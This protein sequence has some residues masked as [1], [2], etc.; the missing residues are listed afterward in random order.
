MKATK[1]NVKSRQ[2]TLGPPVGIGLDV[3][4][5]AFDRQ[6]VQ[7]MRRYAGQYVALSGGSVVDHDPDDEALA[8]RMFKKVG[9]APFYLARLEYPATVC[10]LPSPKVAG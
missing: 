5:E 6:R 2:Q 9:D 8:A 7:L 10:D 4:R 1:E 3:E